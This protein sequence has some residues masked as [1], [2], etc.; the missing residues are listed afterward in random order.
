MTTTTT[1]DVSDSD[2]NQTY[3]ATGEADE[4]R[5]RRLADHGFD[6]DVVYDIGADVGS[7]TM[8]A[9]KVFPA[10]KIVAVE[11]NPWSFPRLAQNVAGI[12]EIVLVN[13]AIGRG[14]MFEP[15]PPVNP[16]HW[17]VV[18]Q[19]APTWDEKLV[20][21]AVPGVRLADLYAQHGGERYIVKIDVES[22]EYDVVTDPESR[23]VIIGSAYFAAELHLWGRTHELMLHVVDTLMRFLFDLAQTHTI[24][25]KAYGLCM[26][27]WAKR[28]GPDGS[29][30]AD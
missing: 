1:D 20:P 2:R 19:G 6:P 7:V 16:L 22:G 21:S 10:A 28:R 14:P 12:S 11:P 15:R 29:V 25:T 18:S 3:L 23:K 17:M 9:H 5:F 13:A 26:Y 27:V 4:Y 24:H 8:F 30:E